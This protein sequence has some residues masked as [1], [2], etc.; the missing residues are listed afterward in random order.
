M[1]EVIRYVRR[2]IPVGDLL[3]QSAGMTGLNR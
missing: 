2:S 3:C 1:G